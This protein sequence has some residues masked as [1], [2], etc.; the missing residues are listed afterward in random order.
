MYIA[1]TYMKFRNNKLYIDER[2]LKLNIIVNYKKMFYFLLVDKPL[3]FIYE[4][5]L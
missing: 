1:N 2:I 3:D 5:K 4:G